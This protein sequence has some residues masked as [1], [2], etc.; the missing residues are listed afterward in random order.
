MFPAKTFE[1][2]TSASR[3]LVRAQAEIR[4][5]NGADSSNAFSSQAIEA[6]I[7]L[8]YPIGR[9][10]HALGASD[11]SLDDL[12]RIYARMRVSFYQNREEFLR[13]KVVLF[14]RLAKLDI[15]QLRVMARHAQQFSPLWTTKE[16]ASPSIEELRKYI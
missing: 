11:D 7:Q 12:P 13:L 16:Y 5:P 2:N 10:L 6:L 15:E 1:K 8:G 4:L 9:Y 14:S 3:L